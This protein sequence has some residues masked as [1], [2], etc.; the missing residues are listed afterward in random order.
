MGQTLTSQI[1]CL[2]CG[3]FFFAER[4]HDF[5]CSGCEFVYKFIQSEGLGRYYKIRDSNP[6]QNPTPAEPKFSNFNFCDDPEF[7][8]TVSPDGLRLRFYLSGLNCTACLWLLEKLPAFCDDAESARVN[9]ATSTIEVWRKSEG[10][11]AAIA[12]K[13]DQFGYRPHAIR[14]SENSVRLQTKEFRKDLIRVG[15]AGASTGNI[16]IFAA[17]L[18]SGA[19]GSLAEHFRLLSGILALPVLTY[20]A[21]PF[22][23]SAYAALKSKHLNLD[24]PIVI[25]I[26]AGII[27]SLF[28]IWDSTEKV[29]FDSLS[30]LVFLLLGSRLFLQRVQQK[31]LRS[32]SFENEL[33][34]S[35]VQRLNQRGTPEIVSS[36]SL[37]KGDCILIHR[38]NIIPVDGFVKSGKSE[39]N[40]AILT[41]ESDLLSVTRGDRVEAGSR[42]VTGE[43]VLK[44]ENSTTETRLAKILRDTENSTKSKSKFVHFS[45]QISQWFILIVLITAALLVGSFLSSDPSEGI[46]RAL[47]MVIVTCPCVFGIAIPLSMSL[48]IQVAAKKG[49]IVKNADA[50]ERLWKVKNLFFDKTGTLTTGDMEVLATTPTDHSHLGIALGLEKDQTHPVGRALTKYIRNLEVKS[51]QFDHVVA[52]TGGGVQGELSGIIFSLKPIDQTFS[53]SKVI[54]STFGLFRDQELIKT[55]KLRD[56]IRPQ[57]LS[58]LTWARENNFGTHLISGDRR[59]VVEEYAAILGFRTK[60]TQGELTPEAKAQAIRSFENS[61]MIG[62]GANDSAALAAADVGIAVCGSLEASLRAADVYLTKTNLNTITTLIS[63]SRLTKNAIYRNLFFSASFNVLSGTLAA[64]GLMTPLWAAVL[65]PMSSLTVLLSA[66]WTGRQLSRLKVQS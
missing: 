21:W 18:Y 1:S 47:A 46:S 33:L 10:S 55:F 13:L 23:R 26:I 63:I 60:D 9:M 42:N 17:S 31:Q 58:L 52:L 8:K 14:D 57:A 54:K 5:C 32:L 4:P 64:I 19:T 6:P 62:D 40:T 53:D 39:I 59:K 27:S 20:C 61:A 34:V 45:D 12:Q 2:H 28:G 29:Y 49:I 30:T 24:V 50:V 36:L 56:E 51:V 15:I 3:T 66:M 44:V 35:S 38:D 22:Y 25:A 11:F 37:T 43:F 65:M 41:G 7:I 48:A 16:M